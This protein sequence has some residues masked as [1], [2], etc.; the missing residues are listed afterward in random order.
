M[1]RIEDELEV[2]SLDAPG[3][4]AYKN[5]RV[6]SAFDQQTLSLFTGVKTWAK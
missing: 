2:L 3:A 1:K 6:S 5:S 4:A